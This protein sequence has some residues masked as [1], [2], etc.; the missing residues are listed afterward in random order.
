MH[1]KVMS[2]N[3]CCVLLNAKATLQVF[4]FVF[5][6]NLWFLNVILNSVVVELA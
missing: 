3:K 4:L 1:W 5:M 6:A 2:D